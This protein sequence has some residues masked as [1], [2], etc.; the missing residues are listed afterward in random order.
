MTY[1]LIFSTAANQAEADKI[2]DALLSA[3]KA[4]CVQMASVESAYHW[5]GKIER[6]TEIHLT[7]KT[8][9]DLYSA[10]EKI[11]LDNHSYETP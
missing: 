4:S 5:K 2:A 10:A 1:C 9:D 11:I 6:A 7:I 3:G 8:R